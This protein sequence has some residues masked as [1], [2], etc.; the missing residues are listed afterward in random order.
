MRGRAAADKVFCIV[1]GSERGRRIVN[2]AE[3]A[4]VMR[5]Y[6]LFARSLIPRT[7]VRHLKEKHVLGLEALPWQGASIRVRRST[8]RNIEQRALGRCDCA[9][10]R[11]W[12]RSAT[13]EGAF[14]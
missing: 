12:H 6:T 8:H 1:D 13:D 4:V 7:I 2:P 14:F 11:G 5:T 9:G 3:A 10:N